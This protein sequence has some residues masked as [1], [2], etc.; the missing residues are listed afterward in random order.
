MI[1][2]GMVVGAEAEWERICERP[3]YWEDSRNAELVFEFADAE[4]ALE[5]MMY[6][7]RTEDCDEDRLYELFE[8]LDYSTQYEIMEAY[9][10]GSEHLKERFNE[11]YEAR[12]EDW[13]DTD[14]EY[15]Y[16]RDMGR[17]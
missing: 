7:I 12:Y 4:T 8:A 2:N 6:W 15:E 3:D 11:W 17:Y 1:E 14:Y 10:D 5:A 16:A 9:I 13:D